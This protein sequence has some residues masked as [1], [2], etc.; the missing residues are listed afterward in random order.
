MLAQRLSRRGVT[1]SGAALAAALTPSIVTAC[2]PPPLLGSTL[3]AASALAAGQ[4]AAG[5]VSAEVA[6]LTHGML[7]SM[8]LAKLKL[9]TTVLLTV[10][11]LSGSAGVFAYHI[12]GK[13]GALPEVSERSQ[14]ANLRE[15][16]SRSV[17]LPPEQPKE[18]AANSDDKADAK[19]SDK[20]RLQGT[21][22]PIGSM[23]HGKKK[24]PADAKLKQWKLFF[25]GDKVTI[26]DDRTVRYTLDPNKKPKEMDILGKDNQP[27]ILV[28]YE[29]EGDKLRISFKK[30]DGRPT[31]LDR[32][33]DF[34][35]AKNESV[36]IVLKKE[37]AP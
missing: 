18:A 9:A 32:P 22:V 12:T 20:E 3:K 21:W 30:T 1:L 19:L 2:V 11:A 29:L 34:D 15:A 7:K 37:N 13:T 5:V 14:Q 31:E 10:A 35:T 28:I 6:A 8:L 17:E 4:A 33:T 24:D 26:P 36:L 23:V 27:M 16:P 25:D